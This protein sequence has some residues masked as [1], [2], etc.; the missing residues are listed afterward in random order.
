MNADGSRNVAV[1]LSVGGTVPALKGI[2]IGALVGAV[3]L[4]IVGAAF[5]VPA[6][7]IRRRADR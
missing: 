5:I 6:V 4:L 3:L 2:A 1:D 7:A